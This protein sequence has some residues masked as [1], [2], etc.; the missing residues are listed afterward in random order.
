MIFP[1]FEARRSFCINALSLSDQ[2][3]EHSVAPILGELINCLDVLRPLAQ[4]R[5]VVAYYDPL[6]LQLHLGSR[7]LAAQVEYCCNVQD[8]TRWQLMRTNM[9]RKATS[10]KVA[11]A[12]SV[13]ADGT[14]AD[15]GDVS[16]TQLHHHMTWLSLRS[17]PIYNHRLL[18]IVSTQ[19]TLDVANLGSAA[20]LNHH[21]PSYEH[22]DKHRAQGYYRDGEWVSPMD[23]DAG[24]AWLILL[25]SEGDDSKRYAAFQGQYYCFRRH[26]TDEERPAFHGHTCEAQDIPPKFLQLLGT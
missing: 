7:P 3:P 2:V 11:V 18:H 23:L 9:L 17:K 24:R 19:K 16:V 5:S 21:L 14:L 26:S 15:S 25:R 22:N 12:V 1:V 10:E 8:R 4:T 13:P 6:V 20:M